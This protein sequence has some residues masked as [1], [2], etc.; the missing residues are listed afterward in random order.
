VA[1]NADV[2][3]VLGIDI[4]SQNETPGLGGRIDEPWFKNQFRG[5]VIPAGGNIKTGPAGA[6]DTDLTNGRFDAITGASITSK[7]F[8]AMLN[9]ALERLRAVLGQASAAAGGKG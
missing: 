9:Q 7:L 3:K 5:E 6:G 2:T 1:V 4:I 8:D